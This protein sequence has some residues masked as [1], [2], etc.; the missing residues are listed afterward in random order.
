M[1]LKSILLS[2]QTC[3]NA[4]F[5]CHVGIDVA[6]PLCLKAENIQIGQ[7]S[8][9]SCNIS[10]ILSSS[11]SVITFVWSGSGSR[12][13]KYSKLTCLTPKLTHILQIL[14]GLAVQC[15]SCLPIAP[16]DI[17]FLVQKSQ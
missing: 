10:K 1:L 12:G 9:L 15:F 4:S 2:A 17:P 14:S 7:P 6:I 16:A 11:F 13:S 3:S 5:N 8:V